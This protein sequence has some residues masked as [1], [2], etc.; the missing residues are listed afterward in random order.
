MLTAPISSISPLPSL[1]PHV[2]VAKQNKNETES[3]KTTTPPQQK[4]EVKEAKEETIKSRVNVSA[5]AR[6]FN[7]DN[8]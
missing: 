5:S 4:T 1:S 2:E 8:E 3:M 7:I 6:S